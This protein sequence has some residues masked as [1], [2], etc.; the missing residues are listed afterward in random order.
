MGL[1]NTVACH[2]MNDIDIQMHKVRMQPAVCHCKYAL[3][4]AQMKYLISPNH[5]HCLS[6]SSFSMFLENIK[7]QHIKIILKGEHHETNSKDSV[8]NNLCTPKIFFLD[9]LNWQ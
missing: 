7:I 4:R 9:I 8:K 2:W 3:N 5:I 6:V 1:K